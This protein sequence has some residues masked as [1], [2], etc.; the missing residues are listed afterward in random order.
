MA[1][2]VEY[3]Y[4]GE[5]ILKTP[6]HVE[7]QEWK[8]GNNRFDLDFHPYIP[9]EERLLSVPFMEMFVFTVRKRIKEGVVGKGV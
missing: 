2:K 5:K 9:A 8:E 1:L 7:H 3:I 6:R 4:L